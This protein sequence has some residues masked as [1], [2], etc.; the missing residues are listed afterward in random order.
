MSSDL[1]CGV[2]LLRKYTDACASLTDC[3]Q[4]TVD[5]RACSAAPES[6]RRLVQSGLGVLRRTYAQLLEQHPS[7]PLP[8]D[9]AISRAGASAELVVVVSRSREPLSRRC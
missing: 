3:R 1:A 9:E 2:A 4:S 8:L 5:H 6:H 7:V